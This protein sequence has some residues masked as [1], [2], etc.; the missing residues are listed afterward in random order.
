[1]RVFDAATKL[2]AGLSIVAIL[3]IIIALS[4]V[5]PV[6]RDAKFVFTHYENS[7]GW[8]STGLVVLLGLLQSV[9]AN[10]IPLA[11]THRKHNRSSFTIIGYDAAAHLCEECADAASLAPLAVFWGVAISA[12]AGFAFILALLFNISDL[13]GVLTTVTGSPLMQIFLDSL[14]LSGAT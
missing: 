5:T 6:H 12:V 13:D 2:A 14:G 7:T 3:A 8:S 4:V 9:Q 11:T 1:M 10:H